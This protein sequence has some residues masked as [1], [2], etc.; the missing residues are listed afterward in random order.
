MQ[1]RLEIIDVYSNKPMID[2]MKKACEQIK[3]MI[4]F[5]RSFANV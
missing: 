2:G 5:I 3:R 4:A 1:K